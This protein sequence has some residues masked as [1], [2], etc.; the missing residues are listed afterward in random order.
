MIKIG[1]TGNIGSGKSL[2]SSVFE[3]LRWPV[4]N[5]DL[6]AKAIMTNDS[7]VISKIKEI[8]GENAYFPNGDLNR[9]A[10]AE[11]I[12]SNPEIRENINHIVH[13]AVEEYFQRWCLEK[14][15]QK[16]ICKE[17]AL[18]FETG[19]FKKMDENILVTA[20]LEKRIKRVMSRDR[21]NRE[22]VLNRINAQWKE[23]EKCL[24]A[25]YVIVNNDKKYLIRNCLEVY[26]KIKEKFKV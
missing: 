24:L 1:I 20:D 7:Q 22:Q 15:N 18:L 13:P 26:R 6:E 19:N 16:V 17:S 3:S 2:V 9:K 12:F 10:I 23:E 25:D 11:I 8:I 14:I 4:F 21:A 5:S